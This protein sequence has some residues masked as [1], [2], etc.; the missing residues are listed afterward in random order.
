MPCM[1]TSS[2]IFFKKSRNKITLKQA[3]YLH[4]LIAIASFGV[5]A[6]GI[7]FIISVL[8]FYKL[9]KIKTLHFPDILRA[10]LNKTH[11][12][13]HL[14]QTD[15]DNIE[16]SILL[17]INTKNFLGVEIDITDEIKTI[18]AFYA[19]L[20]LL[21]TSKLG[22]YDK[23]KTIIVYPSAVAIK[24][25]NSAGGIYSN[26]KFLIDGQSANDTVVIV[27]H[28]AKAEAY[29]LTQDNV[30][31]HEFA[32]EIDFMSGE[33]NG[34]PPLNN[35]KYH[36]WAKTLFAEYSKLNKVALKNRNWGKYKLLGSYASS[37]EAEFFAVLTERFFESPKSLQH[38]FKDLYDELKEFYNIDT[39]TLID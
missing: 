31:I 34:I 21:H 6:F 5:V 37:N 24:M 13:K 4:L 3:Y 25:I 26:Q 20:L 22:C 19:C 29:H 1:L 30:I 16:K 11:H 10:Y 15:K 35:L 27:W 7:Y 2:G 9:K 8:K 28:D 32:H 12:Y 17:F 36:H 39:A 23:L 18:I 14:T 38:N 33:I